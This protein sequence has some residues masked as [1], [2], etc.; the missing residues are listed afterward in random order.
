MRAAL[1]DAAAATL[2]R[3]EE[4]PARRRWAAVHQRVSEELAAAFARDGKPELYDGSV[5][6]DLAEPIVSAG[7]HS[8]R[9]ARAA[10]LCHAGLLSEWFGAPVVAAAAARARVVADMPFLASNDIDCF[11]W[12]LCGELRAPTAYAYAASEDA[13]DIQSVTA[14]LLRLGAQ[15][16]PLSETPRAGDVVVYGCAERAEGQFGI[17]EAHMAVVVAA[18]PRGCRVRSKLGADGDVVEHALA[19]VPPMYGDAWVVMRLPP[20]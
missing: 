18:A 5:R 14:S 12:A 6:A 8:A 16:V 15:P 9:A 3:I 19:H 20:R 1:G 11:A 4:S 17:V 13:L 10:E 7:P 2:A